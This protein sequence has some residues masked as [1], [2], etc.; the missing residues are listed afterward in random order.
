MLKTKGE[1]VKDFGRRVTWS[2]GD[3]LHGR[4]H[5][6]LEKGKLEAGRHGSVIG[7]GMKRQGQNIG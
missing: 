1:P 4:T 2:G 5:N 3:A 7:V 6:G